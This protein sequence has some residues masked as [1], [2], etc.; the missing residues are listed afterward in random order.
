MSLPWFPFNIKDFLANTKR[1]NTEA[2]GAYLLLMLDYYE[3]GA[4]APDD[5]N[6]LASITELSPEAWIKA[7][8]VLEPMFNIRSGHWHHDRIEHELLEAASKHAKAVARSHAAHAARYGKTAAEGA[9]SVPKAARKQR[10]SSKPATSRPQAGVEQSH[11]DAQEQTHTTLSTERVVPAAP[12]DDA[13]Q[14]GNGLGEGKASQ[15]R[16]I[17]PDENPLGTTLPE[18]WVPD[19][20]DIDTAKTFGMDDATI[21]SEVLIFHALNAQN[22][23]FSKNWKGTWHIFC[24]RWKE[25]QDAKPKPLPP[26]LDVNASAS[27]PYQ[28]KPAEWERALTRWAT[29]DQ[30]GWPRNLLGPEPG[31]ARSRVPRDLLDRFNIDPATGLVRLDR[32]EAS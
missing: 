2:K 28:P 20:F 13:R 9:P 23:T 12:N 4:P 16:L 5:D 11:K 32:K 3:Q 21:Q 14:A 30:S 17:E 15:A 31:Q 29:G 19:E 18:T 8:R 6:V 1:L 24:A 7:R 26:R 22:G 25:R 27:E 10:I